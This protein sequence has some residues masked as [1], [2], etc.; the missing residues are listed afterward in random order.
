MK[1]AF[2]ILS[3]LLLASCSE[4]DKDYIKSVEKTIGTTIVNYKDIRHQNLGPSGQSLKVIDVTF[5]EHDLA[6]LLKKIDTTKFK[7]T[8]KHYYQSIETDPEFHSVII[9]KIDNRIRCT[10]R[11]N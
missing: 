5:T 2:F 4:S 9:S 3:I 1:Y 6:E 7:K 8:N 11:S 10:I